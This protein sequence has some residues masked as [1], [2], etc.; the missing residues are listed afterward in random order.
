MNRVADQRGSMLDRFDDDA[1][2]IV[3][4]S[5]ELARLWH[6]PM[7]TTAHLTAAAVQ[8]GLAPP[9]WRVTCTVSDEDAVQ[10]LR[11]SAGPAIGAGARQAF[12]DDAVD[13]LTM[14]VLYSRGHQPAHVGPA[15]LFTA[16]LRVTG[17]ARKVMRTIAPDLCCEPDLPPRHALEII[18]NTGSAAH[19]TRS[20]HAEA[21]GNVGV[22]ADQIWAVIYPADA[23]LNTRQGQVD[24][25]V[26]DGP[27]GLGERRRIGPAGGPGGEPHIE[28]IIE[29]EP[30]KQL[31][32]MTVHE[33]TGAIRSSIQIEPNG[34]GNVI[35][36]EIHWEL[37]E[38]RA[39][40]GE[41]RQGDVTRT[42]QAK[43][44]DALR[45][46]VTVVDSKRT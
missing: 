18:T 7:M 4:T 16:A 23:E 37:P 27:R 40:L 5:N 15:D 28:E 17:P 35:R 11:M 45:Q 44:E 38:L 26:L 39:L 12:S 34:T 9:N 36:I 8:L 6:T 3:R 30:L 10:A 19:L 20:V 1:R 43:A 41:A 29:F 46:I 33:D 2:R 13:A 31:T 24:V 25:Q 21:V 32:Q 42:L 14:A 22:P